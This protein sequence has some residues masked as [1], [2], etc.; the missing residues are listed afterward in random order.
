LLDEPYAK[1]TFDGAYLKTHL[2]NK[3]KAQCLSFRGQSKTFP[4]DFLEVVVGHCKGLMSQRWFI[5]MH[6]GQI[7]MVVNSQPRPYFSIHSE[8]LPNKCLTKNPRWVPCVKVDGFFAYAE[9]CPE[10]IQ[11]L[12][13]ADCNGCADQSFYIDASFLEIVKNIGKTGEVNNYEA[14]MALAS[15]KRPACQYTDFFLG[16]RWRRGKL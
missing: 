14:F 9:E 5:K 7:G 4:F 16:H 8:Q 1:W 6:E 13:L 2:P 15:S 12:L 11:G 3:E 10:Q